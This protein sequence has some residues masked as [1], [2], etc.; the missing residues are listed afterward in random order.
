[1]EVISLRL[2]PNM[3]ALRE[4]MSPINIFLHFCL[5]LTFYPSGLGLLEGVS[6][7]SK[8]V[9]SRGLSGFGLIEASSIYLLFR[10]ISI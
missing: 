4:M 3:T 2:Y 6:F 5:T 1:M 9:A 8:L 10:T 7:L